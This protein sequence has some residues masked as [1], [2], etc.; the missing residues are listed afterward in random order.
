MHL[1]RRYDK[2]I[3][4]PR[5]STEDTRSNRT[6][7]REK[8]PIFHTVKNTLNALLRQRGRR[9]TEEQEPTF[10]SLDSHWPPWAKA[11]E[12]NEQFK[13]HPSPLTR[14]PFSLSLILSLFLFLFLFSNSLI[15]SYFFSLREKKIQR[16]SLILCHSLSLSL[17]SFLLLR[18]DNTRWRTAVD[19]K[20]VPTKKSSLLFPST[21]RIS[22]R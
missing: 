12:L 14:S 13:C 1:K 11:P 18:W 16:I 5:L 4:F 15:L 9:F 8:W 22:S 7:D 19:L 2:N 10:R 20:F 17:S 21:S 3:K 6:S